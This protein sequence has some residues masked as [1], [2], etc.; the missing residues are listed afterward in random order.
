M[1]DLLALPAL[2]DNPLTCAELSYSCSPSTVR[3]QTGGVRRAGHQLGGPVVSAYC[4]SDATNLVQVRTSGQ[5]TR[6]RGGRGKGFSSSQLPPCA[7]LKSATRIFCASVAVSGRQWRLC[8]TNVRGGSCAE[9]RAPGP[10]LSRGVGAA[11]KEAQP[12]RPYARSVV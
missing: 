10:R 12:E 4:P 11:G 3:T 2:S 1:L 8:I 9:G 6:Q 5:A 7:W